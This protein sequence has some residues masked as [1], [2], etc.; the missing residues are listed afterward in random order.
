MSIWRKILKNPPPE[1]PEPE[2]GRL[3]VADD[4]D[5][6]HGFEVTTAEYNCYQLCGQEWLTFFLVSQH[7]VDSD[8]GPAPAMELNLPITKCE[9]VFENGTT[10]EVR[11]YDEDLGNLTSMY[12]VNQRP[13]DGSCVIEIVSNDELVARIEGQADHNPV[14]LRA[15][16]RRCPKRMRSFD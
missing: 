11:S 3:Y 10:K 9:S 12:Y 8:D 4:D 16:F 5:V 2:L 13:F 15:S 6:L 1:L 14:A 7:I